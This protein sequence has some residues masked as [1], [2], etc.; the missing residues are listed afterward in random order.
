TDQEQ[1]M[2]QNQSTNKQL[3]SITRHAVEFSK[4]DQTLIESPVSG[5][6]QGLLFVVSLVSWAASR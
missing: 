5:C 2:L 6:R 1:K 4:N 3:A